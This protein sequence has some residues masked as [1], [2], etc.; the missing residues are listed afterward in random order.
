MA[1]LSTLDEKYEIDYLVF[2]ASEN[3]IE[4]EYAWNMRYS[5]VIKRLMFRKLNNFIQEQ[6]LDKGK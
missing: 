1:V 3:L 4:E 2:S 5:D 6:E